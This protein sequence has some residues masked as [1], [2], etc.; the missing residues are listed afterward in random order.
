MIVENFNAKKMEVYNIFDHGGFWNSLIEI[1]KKMDTI[2]DEVLPG[3]Q[4]GE[5]FRFFEK[6]VD[7]VLRYYYWSKAEWEIIATSW[8]PYM[9]KEDL[10]RADAERDDRLA[11]D[12]PFYRTPVGLSVA[13]KLDVYT[14]VRLNWC[15][16]IEYLWENRYKIKHIIK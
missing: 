2:H 11:E 12:L 5:C 3:Q 8:P 6:E 14:Q 1:V 15:P 10:A 16:F 7:R 4:Y 9:E 13:E